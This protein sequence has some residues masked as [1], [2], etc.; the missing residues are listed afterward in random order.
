MYLKL[1]SGL[2]VGILGMSACKEGKSNENESLV[3]LDSSIY[4]T[5]TQPFAVTTGNNGDR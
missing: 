3:T 5:G 4:E 2:L 1:L